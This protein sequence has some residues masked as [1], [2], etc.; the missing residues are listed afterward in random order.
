MEL[1]ASQLYGERSRVEFNLTLG[2]SMQKHLLKQARSYY[3]GLGIAGAECEVERISGRGLL[4]I[5]SN[6]AVVVFAELGE[7]A[8]QASVTV[9]RFEH[10][11]VISLY[12]SF[13]AENVFALTHSAEV[14]RRAIITALGTV[15]LA[16]HF[17]LLD[18]SADM[19]WQY[20]CQS[21]Q[22][23]QLQTNLEDDLEPVPN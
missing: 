22:A 8:F 10:H 3:H 13:V 20:L 21:V 11:C 4:N 18:H 17:T 12:K 14:R 5:L 2:G 6:R 23:C 15:D 1:V 9:N 19:L 7:F 16:D